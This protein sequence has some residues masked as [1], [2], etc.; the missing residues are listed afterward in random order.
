MLNLKIMGLAAAALFLTLLETS[1]AWT[2]LNCSEGI[3][4]LL[5]EQVVGDTTT[6]TAINMATDADTLE[7]YTQG[8]GTFDVVFECSGAPQ[9]PAAGIAA[10]RPRGI[11]MQLGLSG[12]MSI[13]MMQVTRRSS[14]CAVP[15][16]SMRNSPRPSH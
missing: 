10:M 11:V 13:P 14:T 16:A 6:F 4:C 3:F 7:K 15:S 2:E 9:A 12:D 1:A 8:K 5:T